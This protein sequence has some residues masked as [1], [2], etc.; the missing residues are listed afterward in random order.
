[1]LEYL[2]QEIRDGL[3]AAQKAE[4]KRKSRLRVRFGGTEIPVLRLWDGGFA[5][6]A[7]QIRNLRGLVNLYD[8]ERL[9]C[10]CLIVCAVVE[11]GE[12]LCEFKRATM[13]TDRPP[14]DFWRDEHAKGAPRA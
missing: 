2:P 1:M 12:L 8:G 9:V 13:P 6:D 7:D 3:A 4:M 10:H 5:L 11:N 14:V